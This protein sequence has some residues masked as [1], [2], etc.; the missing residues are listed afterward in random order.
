MPRTAET[1]AQPDGLLGAAVPT[2]ACP[3]AVTVSVIVS[4]GF[5][6]GPVVVP[7]RTTRFNEALTAAK[8]LLPSNLYETVAI[9][10]LCV[11]YC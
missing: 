2:S 1:A 11:V 8:V 9:A 4:P 10:V 6:V 5:T 7:P 3:P